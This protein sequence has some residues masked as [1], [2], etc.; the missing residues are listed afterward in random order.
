MLKQNKAN[1]HAFAG[2]TVIDKL[3]NQY[4][5]LMLAEGF[6]A[7]QW[8]KDGVILSN[9]TNTYTATAP[10]TYRARFSRK[11]SVPT[12]AQWNRWSDPVTVTQVGTTAVATTNGA[13][14]TAEQI[15]MQPEGELPMEQDFSLSV[16]PNPASADNINIQLE[17][18]DALPVEVRMVDQVGRELYVNTFDH[19]AISAG[20]P[21]VLPAPAKGGIYILMVSQGQRQ[22]RK[23]VVLKD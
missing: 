20:Q 11:S 6:L 2:N 5:K 1:L 10:G 12:E 7:Y 9:K 16:Y 13:R 23:K 18:V 4:P 3:K 21:L 22:L 15:E 17:G 8:Q 19:Q 14:T